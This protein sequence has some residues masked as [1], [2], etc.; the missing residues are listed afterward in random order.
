MVHRHDSEALDELLDVLANARRRYALYYAWERDEV[1]V[2]EMAMAIADWLAAESD[3]DSG[4]VRQW[5]RVRTSLYHTDL[6]KL[7]EADLVSV[8]HQDGAVTFEGSG[9]EDALL[10]VLFEHERIPDSTLPDDDPIYRG[11]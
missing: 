5:D 6:P 2:G 3:A 4:T 10:Q 7:S 1:D 9:V 8:D 11:V